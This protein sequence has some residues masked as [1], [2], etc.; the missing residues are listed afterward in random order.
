MPS[1]RTGGKKGGKDVEDMEN[2]GKGAILTPARALCRVQQL[3][4]REYLEA[5]ARFLLGMLQ[6]AAIMTCALSGAQH[7]AIILTS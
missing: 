2:N 7:Q 1:T 5:R 6:P 3:I 4:S